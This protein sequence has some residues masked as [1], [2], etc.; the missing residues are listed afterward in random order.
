MNE[1]DVIIQTILVLYPDTQAVY[2]FGTYGTEQEWPESDVD[3]AVLLPP[4]EAKQVGS[5]AMSKLH[6]TLVRL[7]GKDVDL[8]NLRQVSTVFQKEIT[9]AERRIFCTN[10]YAADKFEMLVIS[11][12]LK[13]NEERRQILDNFWQ[14][15]RAYK[16]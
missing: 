4:N 1:C 10:D 14:T 3:I 5:L 13:L 9:L 12:Y 15:G 16:V 11:F 6:T 7:L 8:I 2:L